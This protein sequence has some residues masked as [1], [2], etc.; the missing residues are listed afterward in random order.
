MSPLVVLFAVLGLAAGL[1]HYEA[2][3]RETECL[4]DGGGAARLVGL[5]LGRLLF[6]IAVLV[7]ASRHGW[8]S[9]LAATLGFMTG[10][11]IV[12]CRI[13]SLP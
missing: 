8:P 12:I 11:Q 3:A 2:I 6:T 1:V 9:L 4:I 13:G 5:R 7:A 10:R